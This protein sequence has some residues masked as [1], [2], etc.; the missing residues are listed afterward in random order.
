MTTLFFG[1]FLSSFAL[2]AWGRVS[3]TISSFDIS[4]T[5][6]RKMM[7]WKTTSIMGVMFILGSLVLLSLRFLSAIIMARNTLCLTGSSGTALPSYADGLNSYTISASA[8]D[9]DGTFP[10]GNTVEVTVNNVAPTVE[11]GADQT[12]NEGDTVSFSGSASDQSPDDILTY[13]WDFGDGA[14]ASGTLTP[15][16]AYGDNGIY[17]VSLTVTDD[18]GGVGTDDLTIMVNNVAPVADAGPDVTEEENVPVTFTG[19]WP[20][21][22]RPASWP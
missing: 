7:S 8:Q 1:G 11:G 20:M 16:H 10:A 3:S 4:V 18:D 17:T 12:V 14:A 6:I 19:T 22:A 2:Y 21:K 9:E 13:A 15:T 5:S